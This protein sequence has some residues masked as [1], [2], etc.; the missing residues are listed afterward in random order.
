[1]S[2][3]MSVEDKLAAENK[4]IKYT[5]ETT[6]SIAECLGGSMFSNDRF[7][8]SGNTI[9]VEENTTYTGDNVW[10][11]TVE[12]IGKVGVKPSKGV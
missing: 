7:K 1:M 4:I 11:I 12:H 10:K 2:A 8:V 5:N 3:E 9:I 6:S